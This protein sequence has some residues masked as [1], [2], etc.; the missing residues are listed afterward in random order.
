MRV[1]L[2]GEGAQGVTHMEALRKM[3]DVEVVSL[4]GG[5]EAGAEAFAREHRIGHVSTDF[6]ECLDHPGWRAVVITSPTRST[7][8]R[9]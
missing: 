2:V 5:V 8:S 3:E 6:E 4:A 7:A 9:R 1:C